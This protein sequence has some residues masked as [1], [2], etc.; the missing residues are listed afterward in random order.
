MWVGENDY[1]DLRR[2]GFN[3]MPLKKVS[4][5]DHDLAVRLCDEVK[6]PEDVYE[7][8]VYISMAWSCKMPIDDEFH[9]AFQ[10]FSLQYGY[11]EKKL[12]KQTN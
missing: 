12:R 8:F 6:L 3:G 4:K 1:Q 5:Q 11:F 7:L 2:T 10:K 9:R